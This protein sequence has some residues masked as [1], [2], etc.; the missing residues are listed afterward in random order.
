LIPRHIPGLFRP[1]RR[2]PWR[3]G[4]AP[5]SPGLSASCARFVIAASQAS[6]NRP[7]VLPVPCR[8]GRTGIPSTPI[9]STGTF[10]WSLISILNGNIR[11]LSID[12]TAHSGFVPTLPRAA[13][14]GSPSTR[15]T[16]LAAAQPLGEGAQLVVLP[17]WLAP[18][19]LCQPL[20]LPLVLLPAAMRRKSPSIHCQHNEVRLWGLVRPVRHFFYFPMPSNC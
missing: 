6:A 19:P 15:E 5:T 7:K 8:S 4:Q 18:Y 20:C 16:R 13:P 14:T 2:P 1:P 3:L 11:N 10:L 9:F 17:S 12:F